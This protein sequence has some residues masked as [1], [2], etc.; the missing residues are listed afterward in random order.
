MKQYVYVM[1]C[2]AGFHKI[3]ISHN[4][5]KRANDLARCRADGDVTVV[6]TCGPY[7]A[8]GKIESGAHGILKSQRMAGEWF[9]CSQDEAVDAINSIA[10][11]FVDLIDDS[12]RRAEGH[13]GFIQLFMAL[14]ERIENLLTQND[15]MLKTLQDATG[16]IERR[17]KEIDKLD[18][19]LHGAAKTIGSLDAESKHYKM[20]AQKA[21]DSVMR[22][23]QELAFLRA[24]LSNAVDS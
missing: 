13:L 17:N 1:R 21:L 14:Q 19:L 12:F 5:Q 8:A 18:K 2:G 7:R 3:G 9:D 6:Y 23:D 20:I 10:D 4:P 15:Q 16:V 22:K 24:Q 11:G